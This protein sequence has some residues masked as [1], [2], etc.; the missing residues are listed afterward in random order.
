MSGERFE[1]NDPLVFILKH[2]TYE[3]T[4]MNFLLYIEDLTPMTISYHL[5]YESL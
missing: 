1:T 3:N 4:N 5:L 2:A